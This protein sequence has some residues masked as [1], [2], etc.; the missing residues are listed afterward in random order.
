MQSVV[1]E[2]TFL[3]LQIAENFCVYQSS[4]NSSEKQARAK[5]PVRPAA[6]LGPEWSPPSAVSSDSGDTCGGVLGGSELPPKVSQVLRALEI[7]V[8][9]FFNV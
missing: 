2:S 7:V 8:P 5:S 9:N 1:K 6:S 4:E 3:K